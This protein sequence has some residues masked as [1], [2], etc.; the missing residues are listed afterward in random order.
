MREIGWLDLPGTV[1]SGSQF[2]D[3]LAIDVETNHRDAGPRERNR[4]RQPNITET[5]D[6]KL[7]AV[8]QNV[9]PYL[10]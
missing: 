8:P 4:D 2:I 9:I 6:S 10:R 7:P 1:A 5:D 3:A